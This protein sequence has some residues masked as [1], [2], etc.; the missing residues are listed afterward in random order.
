MDY[1]TQ[2]SNYLAIEEGRG[3]KTIHAY[4]GDVQRF[5]RWLDREGRDRGVP[6]QWQEVAA[7]HVR[8]YLTWLSA[9]R[10]LERHDGTTVKATKVGPKYIN[11]VLSSLSEW[12]D[13]L[14]TVEKLMEENPVKELRRPKVPKRIPPHLSVPEVQRLIQA[15]VDYSRL[16]ERVRNWTMIAFFFHTGLRVSELCGMKMSDIRYRDGLPSSLQVIGKGNKEARVALN[17]EAG[18]AL[19]QWLKERAHIVA[20]APVEADTEYVWLIP[21]GRKRAEP[22]TPSGA[23]HI[24]RRFAKLAG[25]TQQANPH[26]LRHTFATEAIRNGAKIHA[27]Q[28]MMRHASIATTGQYLH[29]DETELEQVAAVMPSVLGRK[30]E[31]ETE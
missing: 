6:P 7:R 3:T 24:M 5:R 18:R 31:R 1:Y 27:L 8:A 21:S 16:S 13:Y 9:D 29:A 17:A 15:A 23:R 11:R 22:L 14:V 12:F 30:L 4:L 28:A 19:H 10:V 25:L 20:N 2:F 26:K